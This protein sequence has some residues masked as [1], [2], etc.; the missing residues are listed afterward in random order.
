MTHT[1]TFTSA[2]VREMR[3]AIER[4]ICRQRFNA[5]DIGMSEAVHHLAMASALLAGCE[6]NDKLLATEPKQVSGDLNND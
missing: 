1:I 6:E 3:K 2:E 5:G 4:E